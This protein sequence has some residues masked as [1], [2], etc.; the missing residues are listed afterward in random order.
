M[1]VDMYPMIKLFRHG[2]FAEEYEGERLASKLFVLSSILINTFL[3][4]I[5]SKTER[6]FVRTYR[7]V[8]DLN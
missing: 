6:I 8:S 3:T 4:K 7:A 2:V 5:D 1:K